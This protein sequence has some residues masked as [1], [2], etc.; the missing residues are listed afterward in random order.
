MGLSIKTMERGPHDVNPGL[1]LKSNPQV[2]PIKIAYRKR[3]QELGLLWKAVSGMN[4]EPSVWILEGN[5]EDW[6]H[7]RSLSI[8]KSAK[9][10]EK[11][12]LYKRWGHF[13]QSLNMSWPCNFLWPM[14]YIQ[15]EFQTSALNGLEL[16]TCP[17][18]PHWMI[19]GSDSVTLVFLVSR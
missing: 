2:F 14:H 9:I 15:C 8:Y 3:N 17:C 19:E 12:L 13:T 7:W 6:P 18:P 4:D 16:E 11:W 10:N 1:S 5:I